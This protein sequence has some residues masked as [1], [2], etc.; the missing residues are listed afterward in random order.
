MAH[1]RRDDIVVVF[2]MVAF[3]WDLAEGA[4]EIRRDRRFLR[5]DE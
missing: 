3:L 2:K 5:D 4:R 1:G